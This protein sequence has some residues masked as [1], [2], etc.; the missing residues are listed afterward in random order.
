MNSLFSERRKD[1]Y[2]ALMPSFLT[3]E[4]L[5]DREHQHFNGLYSETT[6]LS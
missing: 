3:T 1:Q 5:E 2:L 4:I 6:G